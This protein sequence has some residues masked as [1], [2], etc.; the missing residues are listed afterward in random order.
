MSFLKNLFGASGAADG[1]DD[2]LAPR[3]DAE[4]HRAVRRFGVVTGY[5]DSF[6]LNLRNP[7][8]HEPMAPHLGITPY[9]EAWKQIR[10]PWDRIELFFR[11]FLE[12]RGA[13]QFHAW[14]VANVLTAIRLP[15]EALEMLQ[16]AD[17]PQP[18]SQYHALHC[19]AFARALIPLNRS[20]EALTWAQG[21]AAADP[22]DARL[23]L[24]LAD[25]LRCDG[26]CEE[27]SALYS[28]LMAAAEPA[29]AEAPD[30][31]A[32]VFSRLFALETGAVSSPF[33]ALDIVGSLQDPE[34]AAQFWKLAEA[35][36]YDSPHFR[37][38]HAY[39]L[40]AAG[41]T[42]EAFAKLAALVGEM[43][44]LREAQINLLQLFKHFDPEGGTLKPELRRQV[45]ARIR[46]EG[47]TTEG[48]QMIEITTEA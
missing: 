8:T 18:D 2:P 25:A 23:R 28:G 1:S 48:M 15:N 11:Y 17:L 22:E 33:F 13:E 3:F 5:G 12:S 36:F 39:H 47:W 7:E 26:Q 41:Q 34:Q 10:S 20:Q 24:L 32:D 31:I 45:E 29:P 6:T 21:A 38:Q 14:A 4:F 35:E 43:P 44:W 19:G 37:M 16:K 42:R 9:F 46:Q 27:A 40:V 30:P